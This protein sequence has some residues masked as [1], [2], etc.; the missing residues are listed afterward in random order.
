MEKNMK[1]CL[2]NQEV[3][4]ITEINNILQYD[5]PECDLL[6]YTL[7]NIKIQGGA[8]LIDVMN[9]SSLGIPIF[10]AIANKRDESLSSLIQHLTNGSIN[11]YDVKTALNKFLTNQ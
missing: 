2:N 6:E 7:I 11:F 4:L 9:I 5:F 8:Y 1:F 10:A 3:N